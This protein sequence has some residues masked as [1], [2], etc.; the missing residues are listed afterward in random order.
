MIG[1]YDSIHLLSCPGRGGE[2]SYL[3]ECGSNYFLADKA[4]NANIDHIGA[5]QMFED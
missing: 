4:T 1:D 2:I 5:S 3:L